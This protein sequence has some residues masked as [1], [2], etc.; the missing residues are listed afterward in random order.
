VTTAEPVQPVPA[1]GRAADPGER[2]STEI[3][4]AAVRRVVAAAVSEVADTAEVRRHW[5]RSPTDV[6]AK[7]SGTRVT[8][9][10]RVAVRYPTSVRGVDGRIRERVADQLRELCGLDLGRLDVTVVGLVGE[11]ARA[12]VE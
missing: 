9:T 5:G 8:G 4:P 11:P 10:V 7:V 12:R 1:T 2:G 6:R 3:R